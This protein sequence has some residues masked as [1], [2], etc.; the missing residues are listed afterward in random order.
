MFSDLFSKN[1]TGTNL[2]LG[3]LQSPQL[4]GLCFSMGRAEPL[5]AAASSLEDLPLARDKALNSPNPPHSC[6]CFPLFSSSSCYITSLG[7]LQ[8]FHMASNPHIKWVHSLPRGHFSGTFGILN[9]C[10]A[11]CACAEHC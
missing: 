7:C 3:L 6:Q 9:Q 5:S 2:P 1:F 10:R 8:D 4:Q 11:L